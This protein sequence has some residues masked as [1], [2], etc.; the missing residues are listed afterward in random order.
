M[1]FVLQH[2]PNRDSVAW[3]NFDVG[4]VNAFGRQDIHAFA[5]VLKTAAA[6]FP[7]TRLLI[8]SSQK[9]SPKKGRPIFCS[10]ADQRERILWTEEEILEHVAFQRLSIALLRSI[11]QRVVALVGGLAY[12]LGAEICAASDLVI[13][14]AD[15]EFGFP[16]AKLGLVPGAGGLAWALFWA[17]DKKLARRYV[18]NAE[19][20]DRQIAEQLGLVDL[21][22]SEQDVACII[23]HELERLQALR[24][25]I[26]ALIKTSYCESLDLDKAFKIEEEAYISALKKKRCD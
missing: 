8:L 2:D 4:Q 23:D 12:G 25:Q 21:C 14:L 5:K 9:R 18:E 1:T 15:A 11:P 6:A 13:A 22:C 16:E 26:Q 7:E 10:G 20:F 17:K 24:P 19:N 3:L